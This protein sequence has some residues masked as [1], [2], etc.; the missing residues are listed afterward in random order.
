[1]SLTI[2]KFKKKKVMTRNFIL[3]L[4]VVM[5]GQ[6]A[7]AQYDEKAK[8]ILDAMS[9]KYKKI[10]A[11]SAKFSA[12]LVNEAEGVN[13][14]FGGDITVKG[15][16]YI[17]ETEDQTV[18]NDGETVWTYLPDVNEVNIDVYDPDED[19]ITPSTIFDEYKKG[20]KYIWLETATEDGQP[21]DVIDLIP[22]N[23]RESQFFK[24]KMYITSRDKTLVKWEMFEKSGNKHIYTVKNFDSTAKVTDASFTFDESKFPGVEVVDLR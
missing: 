10:E 21:C 7:M 11:Y 1:M 12:S 5:L 13:E 19:E 3:T 4:V 6:V 23:A 2:N 8:G 9:A 16:K 17:L 22:N 20:Y 24:I 15:D 14:Q 18:I